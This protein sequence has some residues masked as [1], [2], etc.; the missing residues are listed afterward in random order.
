M[1]ATTRSWPSLKTEKPK[2]FF[3]AS[4]GDLITSNSLISSV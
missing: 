4:I 3:N 1:E 2:Y